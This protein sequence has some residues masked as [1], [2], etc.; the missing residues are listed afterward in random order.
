MA[1][2]TCAKDYV[3]LPW[4][5]LLL[6]AENYLT[7]SK[8]TIRLTKTL[9]LVGEMLGGASIDQVAIAWLLNHPAK[10]APVLGTGNLGRIK[11]VVVAESL[12]LSREQIFMIWSA[13]TGKEVP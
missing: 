8:Q 6:V 10:I 12:K 9:L 7:N 13:S 4:H 5:G 1:H 11:Q 2:L 3:F